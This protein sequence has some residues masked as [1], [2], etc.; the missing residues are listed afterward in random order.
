MYTISFEIAAI[1]LSLLCLSYSLTFRTAQY[2]PPPKGLRNK[3]LDQHFVF[4][5]LM[6]SNLVSAAASVGARF[7]R[8]T[9][10]PGWYSGR[11]CST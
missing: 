8:P 6:L 11:A 3:L 1:I 10:P 7:C 2:L 4:L 9:P 5:L